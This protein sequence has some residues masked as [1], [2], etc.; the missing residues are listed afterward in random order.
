MERRRASRQEP[1]TKPLLDRLIN[2][3]PTAGKGDGTHIVKSVRT[4]RDAVQRDLESLLNTR[5]RCRSFPPS[6]DELGKSIVNYGIP[7]FTGASFAN[8]MTQRD[9][10]QIITRAI[11]NFEPRLHAPKV[12]P[13]TNKN[14]ASGDE[15]R[16]LRFRIEATLLSEDGRQRVA[17]ETQMNPADT[18]FTVRRAGR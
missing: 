18:T 15:T 17:Y 16:T 14:T 2:P 9:F 7:D 1:M 8:P 4:V 10:R 11:T 3:E 12:I 6:L 5:W 13:V